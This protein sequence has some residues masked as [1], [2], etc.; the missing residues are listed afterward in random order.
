MS[1]PTLIPMIEDAT[2]TSRRDAIKAIATLCGLTL[3]A[4]SLSTLASTFSSPKDVKRRAKKLLPADHVA[5]LAE[6]GETIIPTT[7]TPGAKAANVHNFVNEYACYC[8]TKEQ[9]AVIKASLD[10]I[11]SSSQKTFKKTFLALSD[12]EKT[13]HLTALEKAQDG[14]TQEDRQAFKYLKSLITFGYYTSEIGASQELAY[15]AIPGGYKGN[16]KFS[17]V[18]RNWAL[19]H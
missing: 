16:I 14:F 13:A 17:E 1:N 12:S 9:Q 7:D 6:V 18:G 3:S 4:S 5:L 11:E 15:L 8:S 2:A 10:T 19:A